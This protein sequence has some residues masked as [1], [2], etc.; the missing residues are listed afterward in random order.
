MLSDIIAYQVLQQENPQT[1][2]KV[3]AGTG[4]NSLVRKPMA[5]EASSCANFIFFPIQ[6]LKDFTLALAIIGNEKDV[7]KR[8]RTTNHVAN[9]Y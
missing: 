7:Q 9:K 6:P 8:E 1:I 2:D 3:T 5:G 4:E